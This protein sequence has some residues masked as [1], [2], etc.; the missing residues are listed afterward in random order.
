MQWHHIT[1]LRMKHE[2]S[3]EKL[4]KCD[5]IKG[6]V[7][8]GGDKNNLSSEPISKILP[9]GNQSGIRFSGKIEKPNVVVLYTSLKEIDWPDMIRN[10]LVVYY[11]DNK[12][13]GKDIHDQPGNK[14]LRSIFNSYYLDPENNF[15]S[16]YLFSK[17]VTGYDRIFQGLL[18]PGHSDYDE[19]EDLVAIW[20]TKDGQ[21]FQNYKAIFTILP[22]EQIAW[23]D[24][25]KI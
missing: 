15:P 10:D 7:Y 1:Q 20:K 17:G 11:G 5:L 12:T 3:F 18:K 23:K 9:V 22:I 13:P 24:L 6:A 14:L 21:R 2:I 8:K 4:S 25:C 16:I 19:T